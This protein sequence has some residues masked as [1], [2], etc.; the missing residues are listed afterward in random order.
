MLQSPILL[1]QPACVEGLTLL[2]KEV[3]SSPGARIFGFRLW[4]LGFRLR[5]L[6]VALNEVFLRHEHQ[7]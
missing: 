1:H 7:T 6:G 3:R 4:G 5:S 2:L